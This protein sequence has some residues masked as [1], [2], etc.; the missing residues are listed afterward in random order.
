MY[1]N[2]NDEKKRTKRKRMK[3]L[4]ADKASYSPQQ[5]QYERQIAKEDKMPAET[6]GKLENHTLSL[7]LF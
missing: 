5:R 4:T 1:I 7:K 6:L 2:K 3:G